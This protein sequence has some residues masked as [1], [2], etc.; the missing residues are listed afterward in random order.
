MASSIARR[1]LFML[2]GRGMGTPADYTILV[3]LVIM[4]VG[5]WS[6][7]DRVRDLQRDVEALKRQ[8]GAPPDA[9]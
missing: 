9:G 4:G 8:L 1:A 5:V 2:R 7:L 3:I 6:L